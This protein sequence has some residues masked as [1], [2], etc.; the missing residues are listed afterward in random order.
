VK[1]NSGE[2]SEVIQHF[3]THG[4]LDKD[5]TSLFKYPIQLRKNIT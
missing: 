2:N 3:L 1:V 4:R 5:G